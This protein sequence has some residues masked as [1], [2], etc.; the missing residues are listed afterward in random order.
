MR[1]GQP[2]VVRCGQP[3]VVRIG[4]PTVVISGQP[5][6]VRSGQFVCVLTTICTHPGH[7]V[8]PACKKEE[9]KVLTTFLCKKKMVLSWQTNLM[10][11]VGKLEWGESVALAVGVADR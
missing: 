3:T 2:S 5:T 9:E 4:Q 8:S 10:C 11:I 1:S 7:S 6:L